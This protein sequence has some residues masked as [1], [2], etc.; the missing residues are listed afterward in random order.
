M[1]KPFRLIAGSFFLLVVLLIS[2]GE[3]IAETSS[4]QTAPVA[5]ANADDARAKEMYDCLLEPHMLVNVSSASSGVIEEILVDRGDEVEVDDVVARLQSD[6]EERTVELARARAALSR[7]KYLRSEELYKEKFISQHEKEELATE[8]QIAQLELK[9]AL[10]AFNRRTIRSP[11]KGVV[12]ERFMSPGE[13]IEGGKVLKIAQIDPLNVEVV[14][15]VSMLGVISKGLRAEVYPEV[16]VGAVYIAIVSVLD[17][18]VDAASGTM[19]V[20]LELPNADHEIPAGLKCKTR[21]LKD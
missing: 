4:R 9:Q 6:V 12:V 17:R 2:P 14:V 8:N 5:P 21:F 1:N 19:G 20:R 11:I 15:P 7:K 13:F 10:Q 16:P 3:L 18:V